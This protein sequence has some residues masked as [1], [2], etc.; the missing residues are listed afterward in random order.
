[1]QHERLETALTVR[2]RSRETFRSFRFAATKRRGG[3]TIDERRRNFPISSSSSLFSGTDIRH[4]CISANAHAQ[5]IYHSNPDAPPQSVRLS[6][7]RS[8]CL[9]VSDS[10][11]SKCSYRLTVFIFNCLTKHAAIL[12]S[13]T[14]CN[15][16]WEQKIFLHAQPPLVSGH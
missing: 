9:C 5:R 7:Y 15:F 8:A 11:Y 2:I 6:V 12:N 16:Q 13:S 1:M 10:Q 3:K 14:V 4:L